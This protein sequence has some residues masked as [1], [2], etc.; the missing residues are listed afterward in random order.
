MLL[1]EFLQIAKALN[2]KLGIMPLLYGSL[3][4]EQ[5]LGISMN[6]D[7]ID[8][9]IPKVYLTEKWDELVS[10]MNAIGYSLQDIH[11]HEFKNDR[12]EVAAFADMEGLASFIGAN[13]VYPSLIERS[14]V[15]FYLLNL[16]DYLKVY[17][18]SLQDGYRCKMKNDQQKI[19]LVKR[20][21]Q[22]TKN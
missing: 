21:L 4:L 1:N 3:G 11:E 19:D 17:T 5:R 18:A 7:D 20:A 16:E 2:D 15:S 9:L 6:P 12:Q 10:V 14:G 13:Q 22:D 8:M